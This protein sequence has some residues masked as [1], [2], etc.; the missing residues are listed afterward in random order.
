MIDHCFVL[1]SIVTL[2]LIK[3]ILISYSLWA[4][5]QNGYLRK[6]LCLF[7]LIMASFVWLPCWRWQRILKLPAWR[8]LVDRYPDAPMEPIVS[9]HPTEYCRGSSG[10]E[11]ILVPHNASKLHW[12]YHLT[13]GVT[14]VITQMIGLLRHKVCRDTVVNIPRLVLQT[15]THT[16]LTF[17]IWKHPFFL[18]KHLKTR[19]D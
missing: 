1:N 11:H 6:G 19:I 14:N 15:I 9:T 18:P 2:R 13:N 8:M 17:P 3:T 4:V 16:V 10:W 7:F 5:V 12:K